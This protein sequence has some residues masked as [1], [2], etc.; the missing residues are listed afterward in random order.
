MDKDKLDKIFEMQ[1]ELNARIGVPYQNLSDQEKTVWILNYSRAL[2]QEVSELIDSV[3]WKWWAKYQKFDAQNARVEAIDILH[4]LISIF[5]VLGMSS[6]DVFEVYCKKNAVNHHRQDTG[7]S[8]KDESD[9][10]GI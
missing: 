6:D 7:Y 2:S 9:S 5:Q 8:V 4:F 1:A 3:P 10:R